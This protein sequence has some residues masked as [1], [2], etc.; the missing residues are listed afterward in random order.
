MKRTVLLFISLLLFVSLLSCQ[1]GEALTVPEAQ[2]GLHGANG[3][4]YP[5]EFLTFN[6]ETVTFAEFRCC[7]LNF[8][9]KY[10]EEDP[11]Y[12]SQSGRE[13]ALKTEA[14]Q[15]LLDTW[16]VRFMARDQK[17]GLDREEK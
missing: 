14:L 13:E 3:D 15:Y 8:K 9:N 1:G 16:S 12:F 11:D 2:G 10:L 6:G 4:Y 5:E 17:I 7:Y